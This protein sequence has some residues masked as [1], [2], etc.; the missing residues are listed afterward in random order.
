MHPKSIASRNWDYENLPR[1][2]YRFSS[3]LLSRRNGNTI[4]GTGR[5]S[6]V[7]KTIDSYLG[8]GGFFNPEHMNHMLVRDLLIECR[9]EIVGLRN[10]LDITKE[11][12]NVAEERIHSNWSYHRYW[13]EKFARH[14]E[15]IIEWEKAEEQSWI[16]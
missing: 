2:G 7:V 13:E 12:A 5:M 15:K 16:G 3:R 8:N 9:K 1:C 11:C 4:M 10:D 14:L 6:D